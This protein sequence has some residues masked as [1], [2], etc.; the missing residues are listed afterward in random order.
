MQKQIVFTDRSN[1]NVNYILSSIRPSMPLTT[2]QEYDLWQRMRCGSKT[3][4]EQLIV[5]NLRYV[6]TIAKKYVGSKASLDDLIQSGNEGLV[7]AVDKFDASLGCRLISYATWYIENEV[8]KTA[9]DYLRNKCVS[10]DEPLSPDEDNSPTRKDYLYARPCQ[11][12]DWNLR[13]RDALES[14]KRRAEERQYGLG[15]LTAELHQ[16]LLDGYTTSDFARRHKLT[17][18]QMN[19]LFTILHEEAA[20]FL[21]MAA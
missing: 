7:R 20:S 4:R 3:A 6:V 21:P 16:M 9:Y 13:Y 17:E 12:T 14:L 8:R 2:E 1:D 18:S 5:A 10:L 11:S 15:R 19:R